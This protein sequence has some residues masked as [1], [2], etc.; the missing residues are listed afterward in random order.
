MVYS[1]PG[2]EIM[3]TLGW[4]TSSHILQTYFPEKFFEKEVKKNIKIM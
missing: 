2:K 1:Y 4:S 3:Y